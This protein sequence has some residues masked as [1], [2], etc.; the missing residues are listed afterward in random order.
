MSIETDTGPD[1]VPRGGEGDRMNAM[2]RRRLERAVRVRD[3]L[4][5]HRTDTGG[6]EATPLARLEELIARAEALAA[7]QRAGFVA[8]QGSF[9]QR[10][11]VRRALQSKLLRYLAGVGVVAAKENAELG[12]QFRLPQGRAPNQA[13]VTVAK[14][15]LEKATEHKDLLIKQGL[16]ENVLADIATALHQFEQTLEA[17]RAA[18]REHVGASGDLRAVASEITEQV[19]LLEG[20]VRYRFGDDAE[21][22]TAWASARNVLGPFRSHG[23][24]AAG[25]VTPAVIK[26]AA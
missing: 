1:T 8:A 9:E 25:G 26:P 14:H 7:Q 5:A 13:F 23:E 18:R 11:K 19:Q 24:P 3:F 10:A 15:M 4:R 17:T 22:M 2:L 16:A 6:P 12:A 21:L 20:L